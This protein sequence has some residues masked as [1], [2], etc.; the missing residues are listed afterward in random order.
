M[1]PPAAAPV[2]PP[3]PA[4]APA[5]ASGAEI[6]RA[7]CEGAGLPP[8]AYLTSDATALA[9]ELGRTMQVTANQ[10]M[11]MLQDRASAKKF[12]KGGERTM[13]GNTACVHRVHLGGIQIRV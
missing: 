6:I 13:M 7:F 9:R 3:A 11:A 12:T 5:G 8:D 4:A 1:V 2:A 10:L